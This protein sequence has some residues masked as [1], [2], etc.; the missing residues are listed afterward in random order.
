MVICAR[1]SPSLPF[2]NIA[3]KK[4]QK[5]NSPS[6]PFNRA[7]RLFLFSRYLALNVILGRTFWIGVWGFDLSTIK[8]SSVSHMPSN[9]RK[10]ASACYSPPPQVCS[11]ESHKQFIQINYIFHSLLSASQSTL[12]SFFSHYLHSIVSRNVVFKFHKLYL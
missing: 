6:F 12:L 5:P 8:R 7:E 2:K 10:D 1:N 3:I 11:K 4:L 9:K